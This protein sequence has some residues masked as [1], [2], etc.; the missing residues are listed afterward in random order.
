MSQSCTFQILSA[1][2]KQ[3]RG[4]GARCLTFTLDFVKNA[5]KA[6]T[7]HLYKLNGSQE[8]TLCTAVL[9]DTT[10]NI[11]KILNLI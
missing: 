6:V 5:N 1:R 10:G 7:L 4:Q 2:C 8:Q 3:E 9:Q 11:S